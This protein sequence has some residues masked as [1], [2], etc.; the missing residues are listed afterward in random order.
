MS[1]RR[2]EDLPE[3]MKTPEVK[4]YYDILRKKGPELA[5]KR[6]FDLC[7]SAVLMVVLSP[8]MLVVAILIRKDSKGPALYK[9]IRVTQYGKEFEICKF[10]S[11]EVSKKK[12]PELTIGEDERITKVGK[13]IRKHRIDEFPQLVNVFKGEMSFVGTRPEVPKYV[14]CYTPEMQATLLLPA[15]V[16]SNASIQY[17]EESDELNQAEEPVE[18]YIQTI[19]P[20]KMK[21]NLEDLRSFSIARE[22]RILFRTVF[23]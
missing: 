21:Y 22:I 5:V 16:T 17:K 19:L 13:F 6:A 12:E 10:R 9:Q 14:K 2:W 23:G 20:E 1:L 3:E 18:Y 15:G 11:M 7:A 4:Q 8:V